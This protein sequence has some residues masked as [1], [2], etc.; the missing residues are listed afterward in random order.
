MD[1]Q[2]MA[3]NTQAESDTA[4]NSTPEIEE[5]TTEEVT[6][7]DMEATAEVSESEAE[8]GDEP[9]KGA[10]QR[11]RELANAKRDA[12]ARA[13]S[14]EQ[15]LAELT[16]QFAPQ[17]PQGLYTPQ[18]EPGTEIDQVTLQQ[19]MQRTALSAAQLISAQERNFSRINRESTEVIKKYPQLDPDSDLFDEDL[20][21]SVTDAIEAHLKANPTG[22]VKTKVDQWMKP[23]QRSVANKV[24]QE[25]ETL[26]KQVS[27]A[28]TR[29][30]AVVRA[31]RSPAEKSIKELE[32]ELGFVS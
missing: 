10:N 11:I 18:F 3:L 21:N 2:D 23:Y 14:L 31:D 9:K 13:Q 1:D 19:Q 22:S 12:E 5:Q 20:S 7:P 32:A 25:R 29:P 27:Q 17:D 4:V 6:Q 16:G 28:A 30:S 8:T 26:A 15:R 24:G